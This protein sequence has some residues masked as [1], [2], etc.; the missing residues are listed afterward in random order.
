MEKNKF[1]I[2]KIIRY[3]NIKFDYIKSV[4]Q[5]KDKE[6]IDLEELS[7][8]KLVQVENILIESDPDSFIQDITKLTNVARIDI[9]LELMPTIL[10]KEYHNSVVIE[11]TTKNNVNKTLINSYNLVLQASTKQLLDDFNSNKLN[12]LQNAELFLK[13]LEIVNEKKD[14]KN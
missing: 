14:K 4:Y 10:D 12:A 3:Y 8:K 5:L 6:Y 7:Y 2:A 1:K 9:N 13:L 11:D